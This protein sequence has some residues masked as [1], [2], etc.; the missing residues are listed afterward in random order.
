ML[1]IFESSVYYGMKTKIYPQVFNI[2]WEKFLR[3]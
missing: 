2:T 3:N 1:N